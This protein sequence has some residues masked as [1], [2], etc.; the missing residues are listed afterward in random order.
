MDIKLLGQKRE[1]LEKARVILKEKFVGLD[2]I[3]DQIISNIEAWYLMP[4]VVNRPIIVNLW[5]LTGVGKTDLVRRLVKIL[6]FSDRYLEIQ[7][8]TKTDY[9]SSVKSIL[10]SSNIEEG[11]PGIIL[12]DEIQRFRSIDEQGEEIREKDFQDVW[13]LLSDGKFDGE[14][15]KSELT[16]EILDILY[17]RESQALKVQG[18]KKPKSPDELAKNLNPVTFEFEN[19]DDEEIDQSQRKFK[20]GYLFAR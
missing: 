5:G 10:L 12:L 6:E 4:E 13:M 19:E 1:K 14:H 3:I 16:G 17:S 20:L 9:R 2:N 15:T 18:K 8:D 11:Q 7:M